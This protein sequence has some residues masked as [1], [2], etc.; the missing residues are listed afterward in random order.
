MSKSEEFIPIRTVIEGCWPGEW[1]TDPVGGDGN[2]VVF[3][4]TDIDSDGHLNLDGGASRCVFPA[5]L[6]A[7]SL[8]RGDILLEAS[9]GAPDK[10]VGRVA[11][12]D[13]HP[14][15]PSLTSNFFRF[16]RPVE[17][18]DA[19]FL[20]FQLVALNR[21]SAIWRYQQQ[22]TGLINL[23]VEDYLGHKV[24]CPSK[25]H[26]QRIAHILTGI[27]TAI[28]KTEALITKYQQIKAGLMHDLFTRGV[29]PNGQLRPPRDQ[30][31]EL[32]QETVIGWIPQEW[33]VRELWTVA[34]VLD[35][36]PDHRTP[37]ESEEGVPYVGIGDF[38]KY[39]ELTLHSCRKI[40]RE[41]YEKQQL[42]FSVEEGD[43]IY[44]KIGTIGQPKRLPFGGYAV[45]AN[46]VLLKPKID[47]YFFYFAVSSVQ[48][49]ELVSKIT[50]TTSQPAL[51][52]EKI[53]SLGIPCPSDSEASIIG[54][55]LCS[56]SRRISSELRHVDKL[57]CKKHGLMQDLLTGRVPVK[58]DAPEFSHA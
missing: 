37:P 48:F 14:R 18:I 24:W 2:C 6:R 47:S 3:R 57:R 17:S 32:Y 43:V 22:T 35:P 36:Q 23:K 55:A 58:V 33:R 20:S 26:Q 41:A 7:K 16:I 25:A 27:D 49:E 28:E 45:S 15:S 38:D 29:L 39:Q 9:G 40:V 8:K 5:K 46:V 54:A 56:L 52:I 51:G 19:R 21:S 12:V 30:A 34:D 42:R 11:L 4:A 13:Q 44:G 50:N 31:P 53:R 1:G 10:P